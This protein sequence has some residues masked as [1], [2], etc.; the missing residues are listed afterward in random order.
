MSLVM[1]VDSSTQSCKV[2][3]ADAAT[4]AAVRQGRASHP[5]GT[6]VDTAAWWVALHAAIRDAGGLD[7]VTAWAIGGQQHGMVAIDAEGRVIRPALLWNDTR[8]AGAA[9]DLIAEFGADVLTQRTGL[10][11][12]ASFT[13]TKLRWLRDHEPENAARVAAVALPHD[14]LTWRLRGFGPAGESPRGPVLEELVTDRS[15]AS[16]TGYWNPDTDDY[17]RDLLTAAL[18]HDALLPRV[19]GPVEWVEDQDGR[20]VGPGAGDNAGAALGLGAGPGDVV[21]SIGTSGTVFAVSEKRTIDP[22]GTVA[23]FADADGRF[24]PLV[25]TLNAARVL[26][27]IGRVLGVDHAELSRLALAAE[28]GA[29]GLAL[30]PYFEGERTPNLPDATASLTGMTLASTTRENLARAAVEG[31]LSGLG[32]GLEALR[33]LGVPLERALLVGG[34]A[35]SEAVRAIAPQVLGIPVEVP[36]PGEYVALGAARQA[37]RVASA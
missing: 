17:D 21:V 30:V 32:A 20:R 5:D 26:D 29:G 37:A 3:I 34:G 2:V 36:E 1:G 24:L 6:E 15:D 13:I 31:M 19:L 25:A 8:S 18:G 10:V 23:G 16:G 12:V 7:D 9:A 14:W 4:G 28:P 33:A 22:T 11:P 35:Q 27:A